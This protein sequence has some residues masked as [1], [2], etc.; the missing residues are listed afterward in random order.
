MAEDCWRRGD[1]GGGASRC[2]LRDGRLAG[3]GSAEPAAVEPVAE[4]SADTDD[5][6]TSR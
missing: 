5:S 1:G 4:P 6:A 3:D 2:L